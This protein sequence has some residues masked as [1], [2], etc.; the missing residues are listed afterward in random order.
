MLRSPGD[1]R[2]D[3]SL[4][5]PLWKCEYDDPRSKTAHLLI[6]GFAQMIV[7]VFYVATFNSI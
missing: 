3:A 4:I 5:E 2:S 7:L 1:K 6:N